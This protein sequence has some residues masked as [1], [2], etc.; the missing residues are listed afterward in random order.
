M[1]AALFVADKTGA[2]TTKTQ[3]F[4]YDTTTGQLFYDA[5]GSA[6]PASR[7]LVVTLVGHPQLA[8][9]DFFFIK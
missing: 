6:T 8:A 5:H 3:R 1:A 9:A 4:A 2:F 7:P